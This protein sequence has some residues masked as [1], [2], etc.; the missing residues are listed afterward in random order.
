MKLETLMSGKLRVFMQS[1]TTIYKFLIVTDKW[2]SLFGI[3]C[4][5][6]GRFVW[7][8]KCLAETVAQL[9]LEKPDLS[10]DTGKCPHCFWGNLSG[11][12]YLL[13]L[14]HWCFPNLSHS[15]LFV[16]ILWIFQKPFLLF[17]IYL[18]NNSLF[19]CWKTFN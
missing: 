5:S 4:P 12:I 17:N 8:E 15:T 2:C 6:C 18:F 1:I 10:S 19:W 7:S 9:S 11:T 16:N 3:V 14:V 13:V